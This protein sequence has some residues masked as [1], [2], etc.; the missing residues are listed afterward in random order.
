MPKFSTEVPHQLGTEEATERL[1][2]FLEQVRE[3]YQDQ[4]KNLSGDWDNNVL[5]FSLTTYG[6]KIDGTLTVEEQLARLSGNLPVAASFFR[7][8]IEESIAGELQRAL[9]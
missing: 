3:R 7:G 4:V 5:T 1:K 2:S 8:K 6:F 9:T